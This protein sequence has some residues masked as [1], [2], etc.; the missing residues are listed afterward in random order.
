MLFERNKPFT[1]ETL[2]DKEN[3]LELIQFERF[4]RDNSLWD[5]MYQ[6][7]SKDSTVNISW[8]KGSGAEFVESSKEMNRYAPHQI[9]NSQI[10]INQHRAVAIMQATIQARLPIEDV[11]M[12]LN[13]D[14][15]IVYGL[16]KEGDTWYIQNM[17]C[18]YEKDSLTPVVPSTI[19]IPDEQLQAYRSSYAC[20]SYCLNYI[21]Y[22]VNHELQGIDR[23]EQLNDYYQRLDQWLTYQNDTI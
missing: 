5:S 20:L 9:Y 18:V 1:N 19:T 3:I 23:P 8:F 14:A 6:C 21:G 7:F 10:W 4:C 22:S 11:Q 16:V 13:S 17:E 2:L 12:Q 15:K